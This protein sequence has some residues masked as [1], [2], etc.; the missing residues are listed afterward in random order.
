M[1]D[2]QKPHEDEIASELLA[3]E[4]QLRVMTPAPPRVDRD[5]LM[6]AAGQAAGIASVAEPG[7]DSR[8]M[9]DRAGRPV[10]I[11]VPSWP[12]RHFWPAATFTMTAATLLLATMLV[13]QDRRQPIAEQPMPRQQAVIAINDSQDIE[14]HG[15]VRLDARHLWPPTP[16]T[17]S[18]YLGVRYVALT[19]GVGALSA[20]L[21]LPGNDDSLPNN[22][23]EPA[24][25]RGLLNELLPA[26]HASDASRS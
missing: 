11:A 9:Y 12:G 14:T 16:S 3:L 15:L 7:Q 26:N 23:A 18:G 2:E 19:R 8:A 5:R 10:Y 17:N 21:Q 22:R 24:T 4:R 1:Y 20:E 25:P 6:F 13:W